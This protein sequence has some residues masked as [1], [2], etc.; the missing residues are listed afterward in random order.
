MSRRGGRRGSK[1]V[2]SDDEQ[3]AEQPPA[4]PASSSSGAAGGLRGAAETG[5]G[6]LEP[7]DRPTSPVTEV[8]DPSSDEV[9]SARRSREV[10]TIP[11]PARMAKSTKDSAVSFASDYSIH[12]S[13]ASSER[14]MRA[15]KQQQK[16][17]QQEANRRR[18]MSNESRFTKASK[19]S[20][21]SRVSFASDHSSQPSSE[22][23]LQLANQAARRAKSS[24]ESGR[25]G[26]TEESLTESD[27]QYQ[28]AGLMAKGPGGRAGAAM[29][30]AQKAIK[31]SNEDEDGSEVNSSDIGSDDPRYAAKYLTSAED[32][33]LED[34][35]NDEH[36]DD[37]GLGREP[38]EDAKFED[39]FVGMVK[40]NAH[41]MLC[42]LGFAVAWVFAAAGM[43]L[44]LTWHYVWVEVASQAD[45]A[46]KSAVDSGRLQISEILSP[47]TTIL[48][49]LDLGFRSGAIESIGD[50][51]AFK[52]IVEPFFQA[53]PYL[54][55]VEIADTPE[56]LQYVS[57]GS[58]VIE[59]ASGGG[60][61]IRS[62]RGD[63]SLVP[64]SRGCT[65]ESHLANGS[66][67]FDERKN[68]YP[69]VW[70]NTPMWQSWYG[71][72]FSR[73]LP[74]EPICDDLCWS[75]TYS[76]ASRIS[77]SSDPSMVL[78]MPGFY[79]P[80]RSVIARVT[81]EATLFIDVLKQVQMQARGEAIFCNDAGK[82]IA[83]E[84]MADAKMADPKT[85]DVEMVSALMYPRPWAGDWMQSLISTSDGS[86]STSGEYL[87]SSWRLESPH[88]TTMS[89]PLGDN[90][91]IVIAIPASSFS[92]SFLQSLRVWFIACAMTPVV[93]ILVAT[94]CNM[95][96]R[97]K[98]S[99][100][101]KLKDMTI[102]ELQEMT[103]ERKK[104]LIAFKEKKHLLH[105]KSAI[106]AGRDPAK[107]TKTVSLLMDAEPFVPK[108]LV[109]VFKRMSMAITGPMPKME[110]E[111]ES[112]DDD[113]DF[114]GGQHALDD[115][116]VERDAIEDADDDEEEEEDRSSD[117][118][119]DPDQM[120]IKD[121]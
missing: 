12:S 68:F 8:M 46:A 36:E 49:T 79:D 14:N 107:L 114:Q 93:F 51:K 73:D 38:M 4:Q 19:E 121:R 3:D 61:E 96:L 85:G 31:F 90:L 58:V 37:E 112:D 2:V 87:V 74:H 89:G 88:N 34:E 29:A 26:G 62:D 44:A 115:I 101:K 59:R 119:S 43:L 91:K 32:A 56:Y 69:P 64:G 84:E 35:E 47:A 55:G 99:G 24:K 21:E 118:N 16:Q 45:L 54:R 22:R 53:L 97:F 110:I 70:S 109:N 42:F 65:L 27:L 100:K 13:M 6:A 30:A 25:S 63:C 20:N 72:S 120:Q 5:N 11:N 41:S 92:D 66:R 60:L 95:Y 111:D 104:D 75:P 18:Q 67:W 10:A 80:R 76:L 77:G 28:N 52:R 117:E 15:A 105:A 113:D 106:A 78:S 39:D 116:R 103:R 1:E 94:V 48:R 83:A 7:R 86:A 23:R 40:I 82:V 102:E 81:M 50:Y 108:S 17:T 71:P 33:A 57:S 98:F 9:E